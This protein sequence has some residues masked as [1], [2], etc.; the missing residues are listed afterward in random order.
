MADSIHKY[1]CV[2]CDKF[3]YE[4][5]LMQLA[6]SVNYHATAFHPSDFAN[7]TE[8]SIV[9]STQYSG[10]PGPLPEYLEP[11]GTA[12]RKDSVTH[13]LKDLGIPLIT[14]ADLTFLAE[15]KIKW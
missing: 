4:N 1:F 5:N 14:E 15:N 2:R 13:L 12:S 8:T 9:T 10:T 6:A 3:I 11:Y 7:W